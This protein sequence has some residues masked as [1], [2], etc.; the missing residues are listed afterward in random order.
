MISNLYKPLIEI[1]EKEFSDIVEN[2]EI[3][4]GSGW[5][6]R[7]VRFNICD[8]TFVDVWYSRSGTYSFHWEHTNVRDYIY[9]Q[10]NAPHNK[11][12][13]VNTFPK[14]CHDGSEENVVESTLSDNP[15]DALREFLSIVR[16]K[17]REFKFN[18]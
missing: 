15:N 4:I 12:R 16:K 2:S 13:H 6:V 7:K 11:W 1:A 18:N 10:D 9:R 5:R 8:N 3:I 14:H 17:L